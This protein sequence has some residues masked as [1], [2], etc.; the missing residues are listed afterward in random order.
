MCC[1]L[2]TAY[3]CHVVV[4]TLRFTAAGVLRTNLFLTYAH[5]L[6]VAHSALPVGMKQEG[7]RHGGD[8]GRIQRW[9]DL[10]A[11]PIAFYRDGRQRETLP[12]VTALT[13]EN[14]ECVFPPF[15]KHSL[16]II[17]NI[18]MQIFTVSHSY[19]FKYKTWKIYYKVI[20]MTLIYGHTY[21]K[22]KSK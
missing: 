16:V 7:H 14:L 20:R 21:L 18:F 8:A 22:L 10:G 4:L 2:W 9:V 1:V 13:D 17:T 6:H 19:N 15:I 5:L 12:K 11:Q 3:G